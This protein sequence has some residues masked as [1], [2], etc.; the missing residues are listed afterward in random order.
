MPLRISTEFVDHYTHNLLTHR[1][2]VKPAKPMKKPRALKAV[3]A[4]EVYT[5]DITYCVLGVQH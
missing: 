4:N 5:W 2:K 1:E 3:R